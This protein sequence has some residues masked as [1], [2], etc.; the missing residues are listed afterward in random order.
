MIADYVAALFMLLRLINVVSRFVAKRTGQ[1]PPVVPEWRY[2][3]WGLLAGAL[4]ANSI[5][6]FIHGV[7]GSPF[8]AP[9]ATYL[10]KGAPTAVANV[11]WGCINFAVGCHLVVSSQQAR[12]QKLSRA[13]TG[14]GFMIV[15]ILLAVLFSR[16]HP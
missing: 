14:V 5:P 2:Q 4:F 9:F 16:L 12:L 6:H 11:L 13:L 3:L 1:E 10:G 8:P 15:S 7:S